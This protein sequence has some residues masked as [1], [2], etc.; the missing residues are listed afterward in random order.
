MLHEISHLLRGKAS[1]DPPGHKAGIFLKIEVQGVDYI[2]DRQLF[3]IR[4]AI[5]I[6]IVHEIVSQRVDIGPSLRSK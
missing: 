6:E 4:I 3:A 5:L 1:F 2:I